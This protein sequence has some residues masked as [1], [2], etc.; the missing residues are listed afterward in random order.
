ML[1]AVGLRTVAIVVAEFETCSG[2]CWFR[3]SEEGTTAVAIAL[4]LAEQQSPE[5]AHELYWRF[6]LDI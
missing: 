6:K 1:S 2:R 4:L 5:L 3:K